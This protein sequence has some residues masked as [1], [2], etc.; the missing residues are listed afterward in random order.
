MSPQL[1]FIHILCI[2]IYIIYY[3]YIIYILYI[4]SLFLIIFRYI[5]HRKGSPRYKLGYY[6]IEIWIYPPQIQV[7]LVTSYFTIYIYMCVILRDPL[8]SVP[9]LSGGAASG[10]GSSSRQEFGAPNDD[11]NWS[12]PNRHPKVQ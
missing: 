12:V 6:N 9:Q 2:C 3:I 11:P 1:L 5:P 8:S 4:C 7:G 10:P